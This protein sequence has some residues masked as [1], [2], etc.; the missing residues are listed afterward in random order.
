M[1][2]IKEVSEPV[3]FTDVFPHTMPPHIVFD[4]PIHAELDGKSYVIRPVDLKTRDIRITDTTFRDGQQARPPYTVKQ[5]LELF[6]LI[7]R[8][9]GPRGVIRQ[10]E[11]FLYSAKDQEAVQKCLDRGY[12]YPGDHRLDSRGPGRPGPGP[13]D[14]PE[15]D[16]HAHLVL[17]LPHLHE[18]AARPAQGARPLHGH[19]EGRARPGHPAAVPSRRRHARRHRRVRDPVRRGA[20][21]HFGAGGR[22]PQGQ[23][24]AV[25]HD[26]IRRLVSGRGAAAERAET[27][28]RD[29]P[30]GGRAAA[31]GWS[32]T[33]TT[34]S[35]RR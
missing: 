27:G 10:T 7:S 21:A 2:K 25:R 8:L 9:S 22:F 32:G 34:T 33:A 35:T 30:Q 11:F 13:E 19:R 31:T 3:L 16:G 12:R 18:A 29:D 15:G 4:D 14:G 20:D 28:P 23:N 6:D 5:I 17:R 24:P 1:S 26:G